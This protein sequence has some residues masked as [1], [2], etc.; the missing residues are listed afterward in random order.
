MAVS[1]IGPHSAAIVTPERP[2]FFLPEAA[3][4][5]QNLFFNVTVPRT[6]HFNPAGG[7]AGAASWIKDLPLLNASEVAYGDEFYRLRLEALQA[8]DELIDALVARLGALGVLN[9]TYVFYTSDNGFHIG[10]HRLQPGKSCGYEEDILVP[11]FVRGPGV[12]R[13]LTVDWPTTHTDIAPTI[14]ELAGIGLKGDFDGVPMPVRENDVAEAQKEGVGKRRYEHVTVEFWG[15]GQDEGKYAAPDKD[16]TTYKFLRLVGESYSFAYSVWCTNEHELYDVQNDPYQLNNL[17]SPALQS[18]NITLLSRALPNVV[19]RLDSLLMVLKSCAGTSCTQPWKVLH[20]AG[21]VN[22]LVD[23][24][25][26]KYDG[27]YASQK[28]VFFDECA[29]GY[30]RAVEGPMEV[31]SWQ[32]VG[33]GT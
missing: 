15:Q 2:Y 27:F 31:L 12:A 5:H 22:T 26:K 20:P 9:D 1:P 16:N 24:L 8:V 14:F 4:R 17:L 33:Y 7:N 29:P 10:Q 21:D 18:Q 32:G 11:F 3:K 6:P 28:R 13:N 25:N 23:A 30:I 19:H